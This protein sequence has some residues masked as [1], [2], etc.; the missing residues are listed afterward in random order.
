MGAPSETFCMISLLDA[1]QGEAQGAS[2][3][4]KQH[5]AY[6]DGQSGLT[7]ARKVTSF[8]KSFNKHDGSDK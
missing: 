3:V 2:S 5:T 7:S 1:S 6:Q 4:A 8:A